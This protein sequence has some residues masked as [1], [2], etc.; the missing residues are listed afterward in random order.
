MNIDYVTVQHLA[1]KYH[2]DYNRACAFLEA[3]IEAQGPGIQL[4]LEERVRQQVVEGFNK[5]HDD[6]YNKMPGTLTMAAICYATMGGSS[7]K[8]R[9]MLRPCKPKYW[10]WGLQWW[11]PGRDNTAASR[12][13]ELTK[14]GTLLAAEIDRI[15]RQE[16]NRVD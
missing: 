1:K 4:F 14:A 9:D 11:K 8:L 5:E 13:R 2:L 16:T 15:I 6:A 12:I 3:F 10:P 7:D